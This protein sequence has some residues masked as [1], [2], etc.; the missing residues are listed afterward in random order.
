VL[1]SDPKEAEQVN[2]KLIYSIIDNQESNIIMGNIFELKKN[3]MKENNDAKSIDE[4]L[5]E[6]ND[7]PE[8]DDEEISSNRYRMKDRYFSLFDDINDD[9]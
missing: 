7:L 4:C 8:D 2:Q 3:I 5:N 6:L 9:E 1:A